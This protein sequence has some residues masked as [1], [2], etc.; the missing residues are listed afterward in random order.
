MGR[1]F[2]TECTYLPTYLH[3]KC[4]LPLANNK[5]NKFFFDQKEHFDVH[6]SAKPGLSSTFFDCEAIEKCF[7]LT[8]C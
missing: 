2:T 1:L 4:A 6:C 3:R 5:Y 7:L 8:S